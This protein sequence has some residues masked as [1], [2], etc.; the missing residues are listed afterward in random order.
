MGSAI[1]K[2]WELL[3]ITVN[4]VKKTSTEIFLNVD[5]KKNYEIL[6][7][8]MEEKIK[9]VYMKD[10][11]KNLDRHKISAMV[12]IALIQSKAIQYRGEIKN[13]EI[14]FGQ[15][16][17]ASSVGISYMMKILNDMLVKK[18]KDPIERLWMPLAISCDTPFIEIFGRN[19]YFADTSSEWGLNP[20]TIAEELFILEYVTLEKAGINPEI[21]K[22]TTCY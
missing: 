1:D 4:E 19:L 7:K 10:K 3:E 2:I 13:G 14:F 16:L 5:A 21:L 12:I 18:G 15:Y 9:S 8:Q 17:I 20:L 6:L 22:G 11:V